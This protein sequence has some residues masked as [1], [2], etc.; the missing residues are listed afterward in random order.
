MMNTSRQL[1]LQLHITALP[2][3]LNLDHFSHNSQL[4]CHGWDEER[5]S[6]ASH[7]CVF[8]WLAVGH[9]LPF[10]HLSSHLIQ[11]GH[12]ISFLSTPKNLRR[13]SQI[14]PNL[15][16]LVTMV[17]LPLPLPAVHGLP[18]SAKS[19]SELPFHVFPNLKRAYDQL[20]LP[21]TEF[22]ENSDVNWLIYD[23]APHW[24]PLI[25]SRLGI[26]SVF[27]SILC[28][29]PSLWETR[30]THLTVTRDTCYQPDHHH[31]DSPKDMHD[32]GSP[33]RT[34]SR[35]GKWRFNFS[36]PRKSKR[37]WQSTDIRTTFIMHP[38]HNTFGQLAC[39]IR[40]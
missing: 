8:P 29:D 40:I 30:G 21:L 36:Y 26:N 9:F 7:S 28:R 24:L 5:A 20:Q 17:P 6:E 18:D 4:H 1:F 10:L 39:A 13:L 15:S 31:P 35:K 27:F 37:R 12:R 19:T 38:L 25:A 11:R 2:K 16:S 3:V 32:D 33:I 14:A 23:F 22:L 34:A